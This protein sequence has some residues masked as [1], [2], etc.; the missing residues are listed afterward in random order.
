M[1]PH[2]AQAALTLAARDY[3]GCW[4]L[5]DQLLHDVRADGETW[6]EWCWAPMAA[7][8]A[9]VSGGGQLDP[10]RAADVA[11]I[12][13]LSAWRPTQGI[14]RL[15]ETLLDE[16]WASELD[17]SVPTEVLHHLPEWCVYIET[18]GREWMGR[19]LYGYWAHLEADAGDGRE[20]LRL[21]LDTDS[22]LQ[23]LPLHL[24]KGAGTLRDAGLGFLEESAAQVALAGDALTAGLVLSR[25]G[26]V[27]AELAP[28]VR[29]LVSVVLYLATMAETV[30]TSD[31]RTPGRPTPKPGRRGEAPRTYPPPQPALYETGARLGAALR[32]ARQ[33]SAALN[34]EDGRSPIGHVRRAHWHTYL[35]GPRDG[36]QRREVRWLPP[37]LVRLDPESV[38]PVIRPVR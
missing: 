10:A 19:R 4:R 35:L 34:G 32:A 13:A 18:P 11:R 33:R 14:Y 6:P 23:G 26:D 22:G 24:G 37:I 25:A 5:L 29:P 21:L 20:E 36:A 27:A 1:T 38:A 15:D 9:I 2:R 8:Y 31:G 17:G 3:P 28:H 12:A 7:A 16:L 30:T